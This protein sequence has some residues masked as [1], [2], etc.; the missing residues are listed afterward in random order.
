MISHL[1]HQLTLHRFSVKFLKINSTLPKLYFHF[2]PLFI[3]SVY[4]FLT[5]LDRFL[6]CSARKW[7]VW[8]CVKIAFL[9]T[10]KQRSI[11]TIH[12]LNGVRK[13]IGG[14]DRGYVSWLKSI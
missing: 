6:I 7:F 12:F 1:F 4:S 5:I 14:M 13:W 8:I 11:P 10:F 3:S 9:Y 2:T